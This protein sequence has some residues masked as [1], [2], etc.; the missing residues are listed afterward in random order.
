M[1][2]RN[3]YGISIDL[4]KIW[5]NWGNLA[6]KD[7]YEY[8]SFKFNLINGLEKGRG[9][10]LLFIVETKI[11]KFSLFLEQNFLAHQSFL[12]VRLIGYLV[13]HHLEQ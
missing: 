2:G 4:G 3:D 10:L 11:K 9:V 7:R 8:E 12:E 5:G 13:I 1:K 6:E